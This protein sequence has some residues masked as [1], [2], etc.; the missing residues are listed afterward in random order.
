M[1]GGGGDGHGEFGI[2]KTDLASSGKRLSKTDG[3]VSQSAWSKEHFGGRILG[4]LLALLCVGLF[5]AWYYGAGALAM[6][7]VVF[8]VIAYVV[9]IAVRR[10]SLNKLRDKQLSEFHGKGKE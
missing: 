2:S 1:S 10:S 9:L 3:Y 7:A 8:F 5:I 6:Y 4:Q